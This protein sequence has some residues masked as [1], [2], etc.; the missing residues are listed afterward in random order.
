MVA[1]EIARMENNIYHMDKETRGLNRITHAIRNLRN[2]FKL[3]GYDIPELLGMELG[4]GYIID[5]I[6]EHP[7]DS[8]EIGKRIICR[9]IKPRIDFNEEMIQ[10]P[11]VEV[12]CNY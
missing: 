3:M 7:D 4:D 2:N 5:I 6:A 8:I 11:S 10:K 1:D 9:V 12:K